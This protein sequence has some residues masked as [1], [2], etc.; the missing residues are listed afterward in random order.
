VSA[1]VH[2]YEEWKRKELQLYD[3][4]ALSKAIY[5]FS[6]DCIKHQLTFGIETKCVI[7]SEPARMKSFC[8]C[9]MKRTASLKRL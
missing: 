6:V 1:W 5:D 4:V 7:V 9:S 3:S 2:H 8:G